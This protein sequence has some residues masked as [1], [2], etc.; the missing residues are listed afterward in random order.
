MSALTD[1]EVRL[2]NIIADA[3]NRAFN[4]RPDL[5][6]LAQILQER[7]VRL[8]V[9]T[10]HIQKQSVI[11]RLPGLISNLRLVF[12]EL[13]MRPDLASTEACQRMYAIIKDLTVIEERGHETLG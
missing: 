3:I 1:R 4:E 10:G 8:S 2:L 13:D 11:E 9:K 6:T 7:A 12:T 5:K